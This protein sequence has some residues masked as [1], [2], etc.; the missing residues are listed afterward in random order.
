MALEQIDQILCIR[1]H[2]LDPR[3]WQ[4]L[5]PMTTSDQMGTV[6]EN[7]TAKLT[8]PKCCHKVLLSLLDMSSF[9]TGDI[10]H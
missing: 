4:I 7:G 2:G 9:S 8:T 6:P 3:N 1:V 5:D 10:I